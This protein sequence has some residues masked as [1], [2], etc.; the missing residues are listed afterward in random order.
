M[1][2]GH[3]VVDLLADLKPHIS[4]VV[5]ETRGASEGQEGSNKGVEG[6]EVQREESIAAGQHRGR[7]LCSH[8]QTTK[9][10]EVY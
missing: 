10:A 7:S 1:V 6:S 8:Q 9:P 5:F 4:Q 2:Q 3:P